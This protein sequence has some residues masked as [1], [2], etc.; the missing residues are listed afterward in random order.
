MHAAALGANVGSEVGVGVVV[1]VSVGVGIG[2]GVEKSAFAVAVEA[3]EPLAT[4]P[5]SADAA[6]ARASAGADEAAYEADPDAL[7]ADVGSALV[8]TAESDPLS[9]AARPEQAAITSAAVDTAGR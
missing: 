2:V 6:T 9:Q 5:G 1:S 8:F 7:R 4:A 3:G